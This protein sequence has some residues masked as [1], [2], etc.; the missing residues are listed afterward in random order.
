MIFG[1]EQ[2]ALANEIEYSIA[3]A[4]LRKNINLQQHKGWKTLRPTSLINKHVA[5]SNTIFEKLESKSDI[6]QKAIN[7]LDILM[8]IPFDHSAL[9]EL[10]NI[11]D[12]ELGDNR[13]FLP[14]FYHRMKQMKSDNYY[15]SHTILLSCNSVDVSKFDEEYSL[16][17]KLSKVYDNFQLIAQRSESGVLSFNHIL[18]KLLLELQEICTGFK[19]AN[20]DQIQY[21]HRLLK[22]LKAF[23]RIFLLEQNN[24]DLISKGCDASLLEILKHQ[25]VDLI[26]KLIY[27]RHVDGVDFDYIFGKMKLDLTYH[28]AACSFPKVN[29]NR[30]NANWKGVPL[31]KPR[32]DVVSYIQ[33]RNWLL[34]F[35]INKIHGI[36]DEKIDSNEIRIRT[37]GNLIQLEDVQNLKSLFNDNEIL[38]VLNRDFCTYI[39]DEQEVISKDDN[40]YPILL[41]LPDTNNWKQLYNLI[42]SINEIRIDAKIQKL[43]DLILC[44]LIKCREEDA[45]YNYIRFITNRDI[46]LEIILAEMQYW[47]AEFCLDII[48]F[49][50]SICEEGNKVMDLQN[51][52]KKIQLY[53]QMRNIFDSLSWFEVHQLCKD[54]KNVLSRILQ[55]HDVIDDELLYAITTDYFIYVFNQHHPLT[56]IK[57]LFDKLPQEHLIYICKNLL[58]SLK[59]LEN[60]AFV[61][62]CLKEKAV[63]SE[64]NLQNLEISLKMLTY[65]TPEEQQQYFCLMGDPLSILEMLLMNTKFEKLGNILQGIEKDIKTTEEDENIISVEKIDKLIRTYGEKSVDFRV[66]TRPSSTCQSDSKIMQSIDSLCLEQKMFAMPEKVPTKEEWISDDN[67][68]ECMCCYQITF[69]MFNRRHHCRRCGR[70]IC[71]NC[72]LQ[73]ML[74]ES[75]GDILVRV[76]K[77]CYKQSRSGTSDSDSMNSE[78]S[79]IDDFWTLTDNLEHNAILRQEFSYENAPSVLLCLS[80]LKY[81]SKSDLCP[82]FLLTQCENILQILHPIGTYY[83]VEI[84]FNLIINMLKSLAVAAKMISNQSLLQ[85]GAS[86]ADKMISQAEMLGLL[87]EKGYLHLLSS[88]SQNVHI[89]A[90]VLRHVRDKLLELEQW[91]LALEV[92]TKAGLDTAGVFAKW[93]K[94]YLKAGNLQMARLKFHM[95]FEKCAQF[96]TPDYSNFHE[97]HSSLRGSNRSLHQSKL[98]LNS[99]FK[100]SKSPLLLNE[101]IQILESKTERVNIK[102]LKSLSSAKPLYDS[103]SSLQSNPASSTIRSE[104]SVSIISKL[105]SLNAI[106]NGNFLQPDNCGDFDKI[107]GP[108][109]ENIYYEECIYYLE[110]YGSH[111]SL[112]Q[113]YIR[114]NDFRQTL[115]YIIENEVNTEIF[116]EIYMTCLK[117]GR[118]DHLQEIIFAMDPTLDIWKNYI[119]HI[120]IYLEKQCM[121]HSLYQLQQFIGDFVR[122]AMTCIKFYSHEI[123]CFEEFHNRVQYLQ[124]ARVHLKQEL[125]QEQWVDVQSV[126]SL[127]SSD[128]FEEKS[129]SNPALVMK[130]NT[131]EVSKHLNT[132]QLQIEAVEF[133]TI[134]EQAGT[135][136]S[137]T[138]IDIQIPNASNLPGDA[139][140]LPTLF[141][142]TYEK[143]QLAIL[144]VV[145]GQNIEDGFG[146]AYKI[147]N[148]YK[149][150]ASKIYCQ[151]GRLLAKAKRYSSV[152][153]LVKCIRSGGE[154]DSVLTEMCDEMLALTA[155][156]LSD[157]NATDKQLEDIIKHISNRTIKVN[158]YI[159]TKQLRSAF[160]LAAKFG[161]IGDIRRISREAEI[162]NRPDV[163]KLCQKYLQIQDHGT[164][165]TESS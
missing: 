136:V 46:R 84:D 38:T 152:P 13:S 156:T 132:I 96:E 42:S 68:T 71:W 78:R 160:L 35:M 17:E 74:V 153:G 45:Y 81:H 121:L 11:V 137:D 117:D 51:W 22:Y 36:Q 63:A 66:I 99:S 145:S 7:T 4:E 125:E 142:S 155:R 20:K 52:Y 111:L 104:D 47:P 40:F 163:K 87:A 80:I 131:K 23:S 101:I 83:E 5:S 138:I 29:L 128:A 112:C 33:K 119:R 26:S 90:N 129:I 53:V 98:S 102:V 32:R 70:V 56:K 28:I 64:T 122:A 82:K 105:Q 130:M 157:H 106:A 43:C 55:T 110:K 12:V 114:H 54:D 60:L 30:S 162:Y 151:C 31:F 75:Y 164:S 146:I 9:Q 72:S 113:F 48:K 150:K 85:W 123:S 124:N 27:E 19:F 65:F 165:K 21:M 149:L 127:Q 134:C 77:D 133:L 69:S 58:K 154:K 41:Q 73:K 159:E 139:L 109:L 100:P 88:R 143:M 34:A 57:T 93:G 120:C 18:H 50:T 97:S 79:R 108:H 1:L 95:C 144:C 16:Y 6:S 8:T 76:C 15:Q 116:I 86:K 25:R 141:G 135:S 161:R 126:S 39:T 91:H 44:N 103:T 3:I 147:I 140:K 49:E 62:N 2:S 37:L 107:N 94:S 148:D 92:S 115:E 67:V 158:S 59:S 89:D 10:I 118:I 61:L 14:P 24:T